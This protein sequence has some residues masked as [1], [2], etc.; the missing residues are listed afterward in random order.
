MFCDIV[1]TVGTTLFWVFG[2][3][4]CNRFYFFHFFLFFIKLFIYLESTDS[5]NFSNLLESRTPEKEEF[6]TQRVQAEALT[7]KTTVF[8]LFFLPLRD[9]RDFAY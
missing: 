9:L 4:E 3:T 7:P 1:V 6:A 2:N 8:S 5:L